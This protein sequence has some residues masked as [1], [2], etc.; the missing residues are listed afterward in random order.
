MPDC[1][2]DSNDGDSGAFRRDPY[3]NSDSGVCFSKDPETEAKNA[4][5]WKVVHVDEETGQER[6]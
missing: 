2:W 5:K 3:R 6:V 4:R 1:L